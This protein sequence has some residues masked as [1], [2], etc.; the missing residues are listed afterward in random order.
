MG[1]GIGNGLGWVA[2]MV[3]PAVCLANTLDYLA[4]LVEIVK[5]FAM[6]GQAILEYP[7]PSDPVAVC[8]PSRQCL[9]GNFHK[10]G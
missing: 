3:F 10:G 5:G 4:S 9:P 7:T 8:H 6:L 1:R 2:L